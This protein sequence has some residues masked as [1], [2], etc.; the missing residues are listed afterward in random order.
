[1]TKSGASFSADESQTLY[2]YILGLE[3]A[4]EAEFGDLKQT[5]EE[6]A[7]LRKLR[8]AVEGDSKEAT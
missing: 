5:D 6:F 3:G 1:M 8:E 4:V 7:V 2:Y